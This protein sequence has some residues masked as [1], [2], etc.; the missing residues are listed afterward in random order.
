[1]V[2]PVVAVAKGHADDGH[3]VPFRSGNKRS[4]ALFRKSGFNADYVVIFK[5]QP[6]MISENAGN[7]S[8]RELYRFRFRRNDF[9]N[10][11]FFRA[12]RAIME[13]S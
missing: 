4:A 12:S 6:V 8:V 5:K 10:F 1:M 3:P 13:R 9:L 7:I 2:A 11:S